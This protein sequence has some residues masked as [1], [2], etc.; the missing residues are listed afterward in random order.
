MRHGMNDND[1]AR[2]RGA[3]AKQDRASVAV[4]CHAVL[5]HE[6]GDDWHKGDGATLMSTMGLALMMTDMLRGNLKKISAASRRVPMKAEPATAHMFIMN[7][8]SGRNLMSLFSTHP[9]VEKRIERL[10]AR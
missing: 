8:L 9:P 2:M 3:I 5:A 1:T 6:L 10:M 7:P 4:A